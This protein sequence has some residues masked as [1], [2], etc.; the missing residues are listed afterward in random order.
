VQYAMQVQRS[1][2]VQEGIT[3]LIGGLGF[4]G[5]ASMAGELL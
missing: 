4:V 3:I 2:L 5:I 1:A